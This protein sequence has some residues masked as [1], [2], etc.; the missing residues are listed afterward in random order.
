M[1]IQELVRL[2]KL[3]TEA[4]REPGYPRLALTSDQYALLIHLLEHKLSE[5]VKGQAA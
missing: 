2:R 3:L 1:N 5:P 4:A